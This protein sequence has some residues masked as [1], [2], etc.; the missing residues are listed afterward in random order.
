M[1]SCLMLARA[2][3]LH[4]SPRQ[5]SEASYESPVQLSH[6]QRCPDA[7]HGS[8]TRSAS[9]RFAQALQSNTTVQ[10]GEE[11]SP[12][13]AADTHRSLRVMLLSWPGPYPAFG[14]AT[15]PRNAVRM[16]EGIGCSAQR[17]GNP[18]P[19]WVPPRDERGRQPRR[20]TELN[21]AL[22]RRGLHLHVSPCVT[23]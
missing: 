5:A 3:P 9:C 11:L 23:G 18:C 1:T 21:A 20:H 2:S 6:T 17:V 8:E 7:E 19:S 22:P 13:P 14:G 12:P 16:R 15:P 4:S 10:R